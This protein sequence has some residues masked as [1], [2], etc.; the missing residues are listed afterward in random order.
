M[1]TTLENIQTDIKTAMKAKEKERLLTLRMFS[2]AIKNKQIELKERDKASEKII[3]QV[4]KSEIKKR[5]DAA[6]I[7]RRGERVE[8]AEKEETEIKILEKYLPEQMSEADIKIIIE[9]IVTDAGENPDFGQIMGASM[10]K[11][12][13][14]ADGNVVS[15]IVEEILN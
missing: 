15:K 6:E 14:Q 13:G 2:A 10:A 1:A 9:K 11:T 4:L 3:I 12:K 8:L 7:Y 5:K